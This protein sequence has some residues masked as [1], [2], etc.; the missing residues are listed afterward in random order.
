MKRKMNKTK[1]NDYKNREFQPVL[2]R[3]TQLDQ[4]VKERTYSQVV[5]QENKKEAQKEENNT[6]AMLLILVDKL[7]KQEQ[8]LE[9]QE[10]MLKN[11]LQRLTNW[12]AKAKK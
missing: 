5:L 1:Q 8:K 3:K 9:E 10:K 12:K 2:E 11:V 6:N 7:Q 4:V